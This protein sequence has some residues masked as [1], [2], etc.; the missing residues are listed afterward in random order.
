[1]FSLFKR[2]SGRPRIDCEQGLQRIADA[3]MQ[4]EAMGRLPEDV[5][6]GGSRHDPAPEYIAQAATPSE[7]LWARVQ[8]EYR[9][10]NDEGP[11]V[12]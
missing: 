1:M 10:K 2:K 3:R 7:D 6:A 12:S 9:A 8:A 11:P 4:M 5:A